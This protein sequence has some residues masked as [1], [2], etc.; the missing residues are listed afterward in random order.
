MHLSTVALALALCAVPAPAP[1]QD[2]RLSPDQQRQFLLTAKVVDS[3]PIGRGVTGSLR[4]TLSDGVLTHDAAFQSIDVRTSDEGRRRGERRAGELNFVDSYL[5]NLAAYEV[6]RLLGLDDMMPVT[7]ARRWQ[8]R[9]GSLS[10]WVDDV[11]MDEA[12]RETSPLQPPSPRDFQQQRMRMQVFAELVGD[13]D[14]NKGNILYTKD[15]RVVM[16]DFTRAFRLHRDLRQPQTLTTIERTL[17]TRLQALTRDALRRATERHLT[18]EE[19]ANV[20]RR[21][22][23]LIEHYTRLIRERGEGVVVY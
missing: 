22:A 16:I 7:V 17:W 20:M 1:G 13:V 21:H 6:A 15:W 23:Q 11:L 14:R 4:L 18:L 10:W 2:T 3:R 5:Y 8:G 12:A 19:T 9:P